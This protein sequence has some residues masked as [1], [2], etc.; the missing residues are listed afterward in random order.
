M[1]RGRE[2]IGL[3][4][5]PARPA[6]TTAA[7]A[8]SNGG[9][10]SP[11]GAVIAPPAAPFSPAKY[12]YAYAPTAM[13][14]A[15]AS[16]NWPVTPPSS[17]SPIAAIAALI[18]NRPVC[19]QNASMYCGSHSSRAAKAIQARVRLDTSQLPGPEQAG[20]TP[21]QDREQH[22]V[23]HHV[24]EP[25]AQEREVVLVA[26][27]QLLGDADDQAGDERAHRGVQPSQYRNGDR[28]E[29]QQSRRVAHAACREADEERAGDGRERAGDRPCAAAD[30][31]EPDA[32]EGGRFRV[33]RGRAHR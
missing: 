27:R 10:P 5:A 2:A 1:P 18:A 28:A 32:H 3:N 16:D 11:S 21:Q 15:V 31:A 14:K 24:G 26:G 4:A 17:V 30:P 23:G 6:S 9:H 13:K 29:R 7:M 19:S 12:E 20:R 8:A 22:D 33:R 25:T